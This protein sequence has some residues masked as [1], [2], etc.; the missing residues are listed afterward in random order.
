MSIFRL[1]KDMLVG[2]FFV[3]SVFLSC[4]ARLKCRFVHTEWVENIHGN[5]IVTVILS[6]NQFW[7]CMSLGVDWCTFEN[8]E[9]LVSILGSRISH[10]HR[11]I[12]FSFC[13][14]RTLWI[15][16]YS[17]TAY[18]SCLSVGRA[19]RIWLVTNSCLM[20]CRAMHNITMPLWSLIQKIKIENMQTGQIA[21]CAEYWEW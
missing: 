2:F 13:H 17:S 10:N 12:S 19:Q 21:S 20:N 15:I 11:D 4:F 7:I 14:L 3:H 16:C 8:F 18:E 6:N 9:I 1:K 5:K